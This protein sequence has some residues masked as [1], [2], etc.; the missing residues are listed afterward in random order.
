MW[1]EEFLQNVFLMKH[2]AD[3]GW[4]YKSDQRFQSFERAA[5]EIVCD[6]PE[7]PPISFT[8]PG[9]ESDVSSVKTVVLWYSW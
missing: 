9:G 3:T 8:R 4:D 5:A 2:A 1:S 7:D 6:F